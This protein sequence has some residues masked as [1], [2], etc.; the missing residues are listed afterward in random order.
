MENNKMPEETNQHQP[1]SIFSEADFINQG[2]DKH[3]KQA[4]NAIFAVAIIITISVLILAFS[5]S[6]YNEYLWLDLVV[7]GIFVSGFVLLGLWT[8]KKPYYAIVGAL[9]LYAIFIA[10]NAILDIST[11]YKG[12]II[13]IIIIVLLVKGIN[14][15]KEA[16][17]RQ[18]LITK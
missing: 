6:A 14:D 15:A 17:E 3:I 13:K 11:L 16:Q 2:Y 9:I 8:K 4:R 1:E 12:I 5:N 10:M 7:Y 18:G